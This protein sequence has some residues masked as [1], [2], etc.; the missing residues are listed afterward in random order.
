MRIMNDHR[1]VCKKCGKNTL[2][3]YFDGDKLVNRG[4][5]GQVVEVE[6]ARIVKA[7]C[8][9]SDCGFV[10]E[11]ENELVYDGGLDIE[12]LRND[13]AFEEYRLNELTNK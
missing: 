12:E 2:A 1:W 10:N 7:V 13:L 5:N 4:I 9:N 6:T 8:Q 11:Y 3:N